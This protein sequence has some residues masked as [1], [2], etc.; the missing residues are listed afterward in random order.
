[1]SALAVLQ[2][3]HDALEAASIPGLRTLF[4]PGKPL[5][6]FSGNLPAA[7][8]VTGRP[9]EEREYEA[10]DVINTTYRVEVHVI[11]RDPLER[12]EQR[13]RG[14]YEQLCGLLDGVAEALQ[15]ARAVSGT[16]ELVS[17]SVSDTGPA[18]G[19]VSVEYIARTTR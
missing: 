1:M 2:A 17:L 6:P 5:G 16:D 11:T 19:W 4:P 14:S 18:H 13:V 10:E 9:A 15:E 7:V 3:V 12:A 8:V